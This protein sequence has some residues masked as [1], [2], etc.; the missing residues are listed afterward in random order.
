MNS[1]ETAPGSPSPP[2]PPPGGADLGPQVPEPLAEELAQDDNDGF[3]LGLLSI[4]EDSWPHLALLSVGEVVMTA[5]DGL[6]IGLWPASS[7]ARNIQA[8]PRATLTAVTHSTLY[9]LALQARHRGRLEVG[10]SELEVF[11]CEVSA[12]RTSVAPYAEL[13]HGVGFRL[14]DP[15]PTRARWAATRERLR[16]M[17]A[18]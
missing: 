8:R 18:R 1:A 11:D 17:P 5:E 14:F 3:T 10:D 4:R 13:T 15:V 9:S 7:A 2:D 16:S 6:R 12:C